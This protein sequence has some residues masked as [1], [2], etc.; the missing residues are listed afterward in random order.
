MRPF[1]SLLQCQVGSVFSLKIVYGERLPN[2]LPHH[3]V[4]NMLWIQT[5]FELVSF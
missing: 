4:L 2:L 3:V 5:I 1:V